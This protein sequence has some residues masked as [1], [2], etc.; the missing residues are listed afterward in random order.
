MQLLEW[1]P[2][3]LRFMAALDK[4]C[5]LAEVVHHQH[6]L[7]A[8]QQHVLQGTSL[9]AMDVLPGC[10]CL[11]KVRHGCCARNRRTAH[12]RQGP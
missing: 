1:C 12:A 4:S 11:V 5:C 3:A 10:P 6:K 9:A 7:R 2:F 8:L